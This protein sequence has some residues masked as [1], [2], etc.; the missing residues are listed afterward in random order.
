MRPRRNIVSTLCQR[1]LSTQS[2]VVATCNE[3]R[4]TSSKQRSRNA[5]MNMNMNMNL[6]PKVVVDAFVTHAAGH[7]SIP[8]TTTPH[9][10]TPRHITS[11]HITSHKSR[12][13]KKRGTNNEGRNDEG[14][15]E[16]TM[17]DERRR[18]DEGT[19]GERRTADGELLRWHFQR[20]SFDCRLSTA[21]CRLR[22]AVVLRCC[23]A[24]RFALNSLV[25]SRSVCVALRCIALHCVALRVWVWG[26]GVG[27]GEA[28]MTA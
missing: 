12:R 10:T 5:S 20:L 2:L 15:K 18:N 19:N 28:V 7:R 21:D 16:G 17:T 11:H 8:P 23:G 1:R 24:L 26:L 9:H 4:A 13:R 27:D 25:C 6:H 3:Q 22:C 14:T